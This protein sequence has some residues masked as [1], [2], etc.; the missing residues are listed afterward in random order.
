M[1][2]HRGDMVISYGGD[3]CSNACHFLGVLNWIKIVTFV[4]SC[5]TFENLSRIFRG[6]PASNHVTHHSNVRTVQF[7]AKMFAKN[8]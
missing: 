4:S 1:L 8:V 5:K 2:T 3:F 6:S 7:V